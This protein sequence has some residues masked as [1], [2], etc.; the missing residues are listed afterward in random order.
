[1]IK[2]GK[3]L[4]ETLSYTERGEIC[5]AVNDIF[6]T[7]FDTMRPTE[8]V[9]VNVIVGTQRHRYDF[10]D[11]DEDVEKI[12]DIIGDLLYDSFAKKG[13]YYTQ[14][15]MIEWDDKFKVDGQTL[16]F[17]L[18]F[19]IHKRDREM[20]CQY[21]DDAFGS[22]CI[23]RIQANKIKIDDVQ[24]KVEYRGIGKPKDAMNEADQQ[25]DL[26]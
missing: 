19:V 14:Y 1:M 13:K 6:H 26:Q 2:K 22:E 23:D 10:M 9:K 18:E 16:E 8:R 21:I 15:H 12:R 20:M 17:D 25:N 7:W 4:N 3:E 24:T 5:G 11:Y